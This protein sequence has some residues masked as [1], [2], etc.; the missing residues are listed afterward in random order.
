[1]DFSDDFDHIKD[2]RSSSKGV[3]IVIDK[4]SRAYLEGTVVDFGVNDEGRTGFM[5]NNPNAITEEIE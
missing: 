4:T 1:M 3:T 5:F 2:V